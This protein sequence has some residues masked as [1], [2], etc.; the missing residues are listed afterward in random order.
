[1]PTLSVFW[2]DL[3]SD[4]CS[5]GLDESGGSDPDPGPG[6]LLLDESRP[7]EPLIQLDKSIKNTYIDT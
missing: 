7:G 6:E 4:L 3:L 1:M 2:A 5:R